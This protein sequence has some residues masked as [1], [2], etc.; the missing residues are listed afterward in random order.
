[1]ISSLGYLRISSAD[2]AAWREFGLK[3]LG[4]T[5]G[6][7]PKGGAPEADA[8]Y[9][10]MDEFPAR[11]VI[12]P[13]SAERLL[14]SGWEVAD[15]HAL[16][17]V[18]RALADAGVA[19][20]PASDAEL[21]AVRER[22]LAEPRAWIAQELV[23]LS[24]SPAQ[25]GDRLVPRHVDL[26]PFAV[27]DG[28]QIRVLPGGLTRVALRE[29]SLIVNS[30]QGGGSKDTWVL[31]SPHRPPEADEPLAFPAQAVRGTVPDRGP[32]DDQP[33]Q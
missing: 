9:L 2:P 26:R 24:T 32:H 3:I 19:S 7:A 17:A 20:K 8:V 15:T 5:E 27:N 28:E 18:G 16:A 13:G 1:V 12:I 29:G 33:Q 21:A 4:M 23:L 10:R 22:V 30:S 25:L 31:T 14:A 6:S 11:L